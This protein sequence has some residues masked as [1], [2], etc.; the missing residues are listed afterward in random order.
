MIMTIYK[1]KKTG[2]KNRLSKN[3]TA[4]RKRLKDFLQIPCEDFQKFM[5]FGE[6]R[7]LGHLALHF[8][9]SPKHGRKYVK[10]AF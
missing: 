5:D 3:W 6:I 2:Q 1:K 9:L 8:M 7:T 10:N 4:E